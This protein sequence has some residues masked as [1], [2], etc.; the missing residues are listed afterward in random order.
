MTITKAWVNGGTVPADVVDV[1]PETRVREAVLGATVVVGR[2]VRLAGEVGF[3]P[4]GV[5]VDA[6]VA[7]R[8]AVA[9]D[10]IG[11]AVRYPGVSIGEGVEAVISVGVGINVGSGDGANGLHATQNSPRRT[12]HPDRT[13]VYLR[14]HSGRHARS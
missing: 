6:V 2:G 3:A 10:P 13:N 4:P 12:T 7:A 14:R 1:A 8:I 11:V 9:L 5:G